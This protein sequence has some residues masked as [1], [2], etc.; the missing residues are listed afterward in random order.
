[1]Q[2]DFDIQH[3]YTTNWKCTM[4]TLC[5]N[6]ALSS[7]SNLVHRNGVLTVKDARV[8]VQ[9]LPLSLPLQGKITSRPQIICGLKI[10]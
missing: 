5:L 10:L 1:M 9:S 7:S 3:P 6:R 4:G 2:T 8:D